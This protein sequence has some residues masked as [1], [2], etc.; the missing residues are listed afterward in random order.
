V[1]FH[2]AVDVHYHGDGRAVAAGV[3]FADWRSDVIDRTEVVRLGSAQPYEPGNFSKRELPHVL[4]LL[5]RFSKVPAAIVIDGYVTLGVDQRDG[6]GAR[7]FSALQGQ[8]PVIGVAKSRFVGTP[9]ET[10]VLRGKSKRPLY[11]TSRGIA[12]EIA[13][14]LI[15]SM[16]GINRLPTL[17][18][19]VDRACRE[20]D[21]MSNPE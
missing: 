1:S 18:V 12:L 19:A 8:V 6:L 5:D 9:A 10:E 15:R 4:E 14:G 3:A 20:L 2:L 16:H 13:K 17:L 21:L 7:L 11:V